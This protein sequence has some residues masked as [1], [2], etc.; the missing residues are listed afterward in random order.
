MFYFFG[1]FGT[2]DY[3]G[4]DGISTLGLGRLSCVNVGA[5]LGKTYSVQFW[6]SGVDTGWETNGTKDTSSSD[7]SLECAS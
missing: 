4:Q 3:S 6:R 1:D 2:N 7:A 5:Y